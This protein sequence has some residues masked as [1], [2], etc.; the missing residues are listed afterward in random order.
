VSL[1][2]RWSIL[3]ARISTEEQAKKYSLPPSRSRPRGSTQPA[4]A[5]TCSK[6]SGPR[7]ER[8]KSGAPARAVDS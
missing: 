5:I 7:P 2:T 3:Y 6:W 1:G 8:G 4:K